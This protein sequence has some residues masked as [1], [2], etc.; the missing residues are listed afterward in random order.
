MP[1]EFVEMYEE[2]GFSVDALVFST[3]P[4]VFLEP[5]LAVAVIAVLATIYPVLRVLNLTTI[6]ALRRGT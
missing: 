6:D 4:A 2:F 5:L 3:R 1:A